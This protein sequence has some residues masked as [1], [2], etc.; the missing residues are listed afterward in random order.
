M[1]HTYFLLLSQKYIKDFLTLIINL[2]KSV[3]KTV[4]A[5]L[6]T[7][8]F[9]FQ[10][11]E[12]VPE[13]SSAQGDPTGVKTLS[14]RDWWSWCYDEARAAHLCKVPSNISGEWV[15]VIWILSKYYHLWSQDWEKAIRKPG[16]KNSKELTKTMSV[17]H[18][19]ENSSVHALISTGGTSYLKNHWVE[20]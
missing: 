4:A 2:C 12:R 3:P 1:V 11:L 18:R 8:C 15:A 5:V 6:W 10:S 9:L 20:Y 16:K 17:S 19:V 7:H 13:Y 14:W